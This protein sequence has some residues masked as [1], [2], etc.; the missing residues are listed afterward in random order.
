MKYYWHRFALALA[1]TLAG[2][3][4]TTFAQE[5]E[6]KEE[7]K[8][9]QGDQEELS[10]QERMEE[11]Q[12]AAQGEFKDAVELLAEV[13]K[14]FP[15][16]IGVTLTYI[17]ATQQLAS[18]LSDVERVDGNEWYYKSAKVAREVMNSDELPDGARDLIATAIY[19][20][21]CSFGVD[22]EKDKAMKV[23]KEAFDYG[24]DKYELASE[25]S[26][27]GDLLETDE[28][29]ELVA[30]AEKSLAKTIIKK[31]KTKMD[32]F[33]SFD[34]DFIIDS[35]DADE[36]SLESLKGKIVI[37]D[38]FNS[39]NRVSRGESEAL[40]QLKK[41][42][43][44]KVEI[45]GMAFEDGDD[46]EAFDQVDTFIQKN[47]VNYPCTLGDE[48]I[49][50]QLPKFESYPTKVFIDA[51]GKVRFVKEGASS[52]EELEFIVNELSS[53]DE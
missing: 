39:Q 18:Q 13:H 10:L 51:E 43:S 7:K 20:E 29:K 4:L 15:D 46:D 52:L 24:F 6:Q 32:K 33:E 21:A 30:S 17:T 35:L 26:D 5:T 53:D 34:F 25:D 47:E 11:V 37:V 8:Q 28:F 3:A 45:I 12:Q 40:V 36:I 9:E 38:F 16:E 19:N 49:R 48:E 27:F 1:F 42:H 50:D 2:G 22:G 14:D 44:D 23:L 41:D 31:L